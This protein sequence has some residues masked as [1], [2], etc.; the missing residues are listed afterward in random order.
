MPRALSSRPISATLLGLTIA[1]LGLAFVTCLL[2][3]FVRFMNAYMAVKRVQRQPYHATTFHVIRPYYQK[4]A[5]MH[6]PDI[7]VYASGMVEGQKEWMDLV[8]YLKRAPNDQT[9][10]NRWVPP[11]TVIPV[12]L[13]PGLQGQNRVEI[14]DVL[15]PGEASRRT[16]MRVLRHVP[17]ALAALGVLIFVLVQIRRS[18]AET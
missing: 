17:L 6:G 5:G 9:E 12:Y 1:I 4:S 7:A 3:G 10:L 15:P 11:G 14:I 8:P 18:L 16:E 2:L 13:F